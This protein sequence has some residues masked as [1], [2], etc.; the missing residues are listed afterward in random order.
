MVACPISSW[1]ACVAGTG[2]SCDG[3]D[4][5]GCHEG[6][7]QCHG[8]CSD[9]TGT[10]VEVC[11]DGLDND[12]NGTIDD[13]CTICGDGVCDAGEDGICNADCQPCG[14]GFCNWNERCA[15]DYDYCGDRDCLAHEYG[16]CSTDCGS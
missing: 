14:D 10:Q 9:T 5:D 12:C 3:V 8:A 7:V 6:I 2:Q 13:R 4:G 1:S 11:G 15:E 16:Y